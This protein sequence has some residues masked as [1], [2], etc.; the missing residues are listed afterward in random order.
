MKMPKSFQVRDKR[1][2]PWPPGFKPRLTDPDDPLT[3]LPTM[4]DIRRQN[5]EAAR[6]A[7]R[8]ILDGW[9]NGTLW[10][11]GKTLGAGGR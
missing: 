4:S 9:R 5:L 8:E 7:S 1:G 2:N 6:K 3:M 10:H 11:M